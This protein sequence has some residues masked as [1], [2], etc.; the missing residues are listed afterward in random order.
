MGKAMKRYAKMTYADWC[1][2]ENQREYL[3]YSKALR[4]LLVTMFKWENLPDG[5]S[6]RYL[7]ESLFETGSVIFYKSNSGITKG[8][9]IVARATPIGFNIYNEPLGYRTYAAN[10]LLSEMVKAH[11]CVPIWNDYA[12]EGNVA[13]VNFFAKRLA[14]IEQTIDVNLDQIKHPT[15]ISC[16]EGQ[17]KS[18]E[19]F[20]SKIR[21]GEPYILTDENF[22]DTNSFKVWD[23]KAQNHIP[24]LY[25]TK[26]NILCEALTFFGI[27]NVPVAKKERLITS[28]ADQNNQ[29]I[30]INR[31]VMYNP[32]IEAIEKINQMFS[33]CHIK[34]SIAETLKKDV[35]SL[36]KGGE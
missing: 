24:L 23:L 29:Q 17:K 12:Q 25:D 30:E 10:G 11:E 18:V 4:R 28:E 3:F 33:D 21:A 14:R 31:N 27:N 1:L 35:E 19:Q 7:E 15:I 36:M 5:I 16:S 6:S 8:S 13:N 22:S 9:Y 20:Y 34:L 26:Q 32:R 2:E